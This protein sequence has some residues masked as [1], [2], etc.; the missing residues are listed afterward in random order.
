MTSNL[1]ED[2]QMI[3]TQREGVKPGNVARYKW[4][5]PKRS[6]PGPNES[7]VY[8]HVINLHCFNIKLKYQLEGTTES[9]YR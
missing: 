6:G 3:N 4:L 7:I 1:L 5:V 8:I 9:Q 2:N